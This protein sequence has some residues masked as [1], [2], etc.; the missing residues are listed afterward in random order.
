VVDG[1]QV[2]QREHTFAQFEEIREGLFV[3]TRGGSAEIA[4]DDLWQLLRQAI[5]RAR[6]VI[7]A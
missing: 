4:Q 5:E 3:S 1:E 6:S 2:Y 7:F